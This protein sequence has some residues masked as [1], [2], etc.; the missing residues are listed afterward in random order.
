MCLHSIMRGLDAAT[1]YLPFVLAA[2]DKRRPTVNLKEVVQ[3]IIQAAIVGGV[4]LYGMVLVLDN[5]TGA[6]S[7]QIDQLTAEVQVLREQ[8][9]LLR[10]KIGQ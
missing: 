6:M 1:D 3:A 10:I 5:K 9:V 2:G 7:K 8:V 4:M